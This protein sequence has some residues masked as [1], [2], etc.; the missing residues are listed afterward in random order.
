MVVIV[1]MIVVVGAEEDA[2]LV[3]GAEEDAMLAV[4]AAEVVGVL[5]MLA[6]VQSVV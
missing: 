1:P 4:E 3:V 5:L 6:L 2:M